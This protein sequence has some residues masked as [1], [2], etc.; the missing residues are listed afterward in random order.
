M[1]Q[2]TCSGLRVESLA[3]SHVIFHAVML[4]I[5]PMVVRRLDPDERQLI[6]PG[7]VFVWEERCPLA[8]ATGTGMERWTDG[9]RWGPSRVRD[10]FLLYQEVLPELD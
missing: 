7:C 6:H 8:Q 1:Q 3:D 4:G 2:P 5:L 9:R 10:E